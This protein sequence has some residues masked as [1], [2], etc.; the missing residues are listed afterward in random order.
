MSQL[1][2]EPSVPLA[3]SSFIGREQEL[4]DV[5][6][7]LKRTRLLTL[8]GTGGVGK[9][10]VA[11]ELAR[12][13]VA[14]GS[15]RVY[16]VELAPLADSSLVAHSVASALGLALHPRRSAIDTVI[17]WLRQQQVLLVIDNC[18]H[19][20]QGCAELAQQVLAACAH[21][22][23]L[24]TS[25]QR[26]G[27]VGETTW[28]VPSMALPTAESSV[29]DVSACD[30][31]QLF[32]ER[33]TALSS[34]FVLSEDNA[35]AVA[36][37]CNQLDGIPLAIELAA[38]RINALSVTDIAIRL[39]DGLRLLSR[40]SRTAPL[41]QQTLEA[42][43]EWDYRLLDTSERTL[44]VRSSVFVGGWSLEAAEAVCSGGELR[45]TDV[46]D[47]LTQLIDKSFVLA[48]PSGND[49]IRYRLLEPLRQFS[50]ERLATQVD[51]LEVR[52]HHA[53]WFHS[54]AVTAADH[55]H[56]P[57]IRQ[58]KPT[59]KSHVRRSAGGPVGNPRSTPGMT[60]S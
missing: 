15:R 60:D 54:L 26:L 18:E 46:L 33:A 25:R 52:H 45:R 22:Q 59:S 51:A 55:Y 16:V 21:V 1:P 3:V 30:A 5:S 14:E 20:L 57:D 27:T 50:S 8:T 11:L 12:A 6:R 31:V 4:A 53:H 2:T 43:F 49:S 13:V 32:V 29:P 24:A 23:I 19:V 36:R 39:Q 47:V 9:T 7:L 28:R 42:T 44:L 37:I 34:G 40:G 58:C 48:E 56:G 17:Q 41:R 38:A 35:V 10:R